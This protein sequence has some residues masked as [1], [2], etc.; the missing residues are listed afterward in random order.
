MVVRYAFLMRPP[1]PGAMPREGLIECK[2]I[3]GIAPSGHR[4]W[5]W[6]D[7]S[8]RLTEK[9]VQDYELEY[10]SSYETPD[11]TR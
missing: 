4:A 3:H 11:L 6:A 7:Y 10:V 8:R 9:E 5:G 1:M 2:E